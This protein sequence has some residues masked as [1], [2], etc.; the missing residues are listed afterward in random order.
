V[1]GKENQGQADGSIDRPRG[2]AGIQPP[3][4]KL[5]TT[6][7]SFLTG[8]AA[9]G[10]AFCS[11]GMGSLARAQPRPPRLPV[12][13]GGKRVLTVDVHSHCYFHEAINLMGDAADKVLPPVKGVPEHFIVIEQRLKEMD[14]M[15]IDMEI[16]SINPFWYGKDRD[17][18][19]A[20]VKVQND[21]LAELC[22]SRPERF[23]AFASLTLQFPD[24]A[25]QQLETAVKKQGMRGAAIGASVAG[26]DFS[27]PKF[28]PVWAKAEELGAVLFVHPQ[29][30]P[31]LA[32]R[33]K[34]NGWLS[35]TI[36]NP[37][38]TTIALQHLIFEGTLDR[39][40]G[41][42]VLAAH[43]GGFLPSYAARGDHACFVSP[44]NCNPNITLK[45]KPS[46]YLNQ[47][48]FDAMVFTAE[49]LRH[50]VAQVGA[51][52]IMLGTDHPIPWE[53]H[54]VDHVFATTTLSDKQKVAILGGNAAH[55]FGIK[56]A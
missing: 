54:P 6:R 27:D 53:E 16:L 26:E 13:V 45:K 50:L 35:N 51:S 49:G 14:A 33:F 12:K 44:Q 21:K 38:D 41:L 42:K 39:F 29:S 15:A 18:A 24:L 3:G 7:R 52:Q 9:T 30:T 28:H 46:D 17:T 34:G 55:V 11:C 40:P 48:Y 36:G 25:V 5:M 23:G 2:K 47:L 1:S 31:E 22:A 43:G 19:A 20:I 56:E 4:E 37:L 32:R 8:A 10:I